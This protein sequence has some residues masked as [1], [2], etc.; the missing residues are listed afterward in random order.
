V[1][2]LGFLPMMGA[3]LLAL[4]SKRTVP[5]EQMADTNSL[6]RLVGNLFVMMTALLL[7]LMMGSSKNTLD[8]NNRNIHVLA[9]DIILLDRNLRALGPGAQDPRRHLLEYVKI[10]LKDVNILE[11]NPQG[12]AALNATG[13]SLRAIQVSDDQ[14]IA[15]WN[16]ARQLYREIIRQ[17]WIMIDAFGQ[18]IPTPLM[19]LIILL[20]VIIFLNF[21]F[22]A[23][24]NTVV[25]ATFLLAALLISATLYL[26][27]VM[28][29]PTTGMIEASNASFQ[30]ALAQL[31]R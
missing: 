7:G 31:Q 27:V 26:I 18:T 24:H 6:V 9:T 4:F 3:A 20:L 14:M 1:A 16:D 2:I 30:R 5:S 25:M 8:T 13:V 23:P 19:I 17:R 12:E 10:A 21:G 28:D 11:E 29:T 22:R 15:I